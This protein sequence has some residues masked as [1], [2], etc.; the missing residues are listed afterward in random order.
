MQGRSQQA[1]ELMNLD[2]IVDFSISVDFLWTSSTN[3]HLHM[4]FLL[5]TPNYHL[6]KKQQACDIAADALID[7]VSMCDE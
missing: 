7:S 6:G 1:K 4:N 2:I 5:W 3:S